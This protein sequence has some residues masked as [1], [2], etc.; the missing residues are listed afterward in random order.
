MTPSGTPP[1]LESTAGEPQH[2]RPLRVLVVDDDE[3]ARSALQ[4]VVKGLGHLCAVAADGEQ[5]LAMHQSAPADVI[6]C[7]WVMPRMDGIELLRRTREQDKERYTFFVLVTGLND[8]DHFLAGMN[9]GADEFLKK[10]I[11]AAELGVRLDAARRLTEAHRSLTNRNSVLSRSNETSFHAARVD[12]LTNIANRRQMS[13]D[14]DLLPPRAL[15]Y[16]HRYSAAL[17]DIDFF[18]SYNDHYGHPAGDEALR[19]VSHAM[20]GALR[21]GDGFYRYGGEEFLIILPEQGLEEAARA[22]ERT[23]LAVERL[24]L[25]HESLGP[26]KLVTISVGVAELRAGDA[27]GVA[28]I[29]RADRALYQAKALGRNR[30]ELSR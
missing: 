15:R 5:A 4:R 21:R 9:A 24:A 17:C 27:S 13:E 20:H 7:D 23:R 28:W 22:A 12:P 6:L 25:P 14:L 29:E 19:R 10:P 1:V 18:K 8:R 3:D 16:G 11:D 2:H 26:G 30:V